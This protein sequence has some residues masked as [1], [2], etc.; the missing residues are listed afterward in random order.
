MD[1]K[2]LSFRKDWL[3]DVKNNKKYEKII[4]PIS[5][6]KPS[7]AFDISILDIAMEEAQD[8]EAKGNQFL[9]LKGSSLI[10]LRLI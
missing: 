2:F 6:M 5:G 7:P 10:F 9:D 4:D 8:L 3:I 1:R